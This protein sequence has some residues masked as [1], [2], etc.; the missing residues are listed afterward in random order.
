MKLMAVFLLALTIVGC[1]SNTPKSE[2]AD[3]VVAH[4]S[5]QNEQASTT[6]SDD[7]V[8]CE[9]VRGTGTIIPQRVCKTRR[10]IREDQERAKEA[11]RAIDTS[12]TRNTGS[13]NE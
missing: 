7:D 11:A 12:T 8:I 5:P 6:E 10:Q 2:Q 1:S 3:N 9:R 13:G 4:G